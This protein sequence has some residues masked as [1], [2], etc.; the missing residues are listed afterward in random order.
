MNIT[1]HRG[2]HQIGGTIA[3][4]ST[5]NAKVLIDLGENLPGIDGR[6]LPPI[7]GLTVG[8]STNSAL[9]ITHYHGDHIGAISKALPDVRVFM[10]EATRDIQIVKGRRLAGVVDDERDQ[11][12]RYEQAQTFKA[13]D[14]ITIGDITVTPFFVDHSAFDSYMFLIEAEGKKILHMGDFRSHGFKGKGLI[15][16]LKTYVGKVDV[17]ITEGTMLSRDDEKVIPERELQHNAKEFLNQYK[18][19]FV[20]CSSTNIDRIAAVYQ[21][22]PRG[23]YFICDDYQKEVL[24]VVQ[25]HSSCYTDLYSFDKALIYGDNLQSRLMDR[26]FCM[27]VRA[28]P[29]FSKTMAQFDKSKSIILYSMWKGYLNDEQYNYKA[30]LADYKWEDLHTSGHADKKTLIEVMTTVMPK[31]GV[32][33]IHSDCPEAFTTM[34]LPCETIFLKDRQVFSL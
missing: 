2:T 24:D 34:E 21:A 20:L 17:L 1:I 15:P 27:L 11:L 12:P 3:E 32:I 8:D 18:Y 31:V 4:I 30:F 19:V 33:P 25:K 14:S 29:Y 7:D 28:N 10:G 16:T 9:F 22:T 26:G 5:K 13:R 6:T 23:K